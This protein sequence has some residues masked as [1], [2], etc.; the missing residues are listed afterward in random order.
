VAETFDIDTSPLLPGIYN[1]R[2]E[3]TDRSSG[4]RRTRGC[5]FE[6]RDYE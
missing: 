5:T 2:V 4:T 6:I 1:L 3:V